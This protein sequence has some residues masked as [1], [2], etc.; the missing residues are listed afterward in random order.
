MIELQGDIWQN[1]EHSDWV[2]ITTNGGTNKSGQAI[3]GKGIALEAKERFPQLP[4]LLG[5]KLLSTGNT[6]YTFP[7]YGIIT[8]PTKE[9]FWEKSTLQLISTSARCL[10]N[11]VAD[12]GL[13]GRILLPRPGCGNGKLTW[14][15]VKPVIE[16]FFG[17][18]Q[19]VIFRR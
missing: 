9:N 15:Q 3:M 12:F 8:F 7:A 19:Y 14:K 10:S 18:D 1:A 13:C 6:V 5:F 16:P 2:T 4:A 11:L 17:S